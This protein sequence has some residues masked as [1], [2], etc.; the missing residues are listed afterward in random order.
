MSLDDVALGFE[1][2]DVG[3]EG[4]A[5]DGIYGV[6]HQVSLQVDDR[7]STGGS[8]PTALEASHHHVER[9]EECFDVT[10][11]QGRHDHSTLPPPDRVVGEEEPFL[12]AHLPRDPAL[13][14]RPPEALGPLAKDR[15]DHRVVADQEQAARADSYAH[16]RTIGGD[17]LRKFL[18]HPRLLELKG[19]TEDRHAPRPRKILVSPSR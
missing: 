14:R 12:E 4:Q 10:W 6:A 1:R 5:G 8:A 13:V 19:V 15:T 3:A 9:R 16:V 2:V 18:M 7:A 17:P 11:V